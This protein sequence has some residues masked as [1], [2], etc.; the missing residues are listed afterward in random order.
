MNATRLKRVS[1]ITARGRAAAPF[2]LGMTK[3]FA[4]NDNGLYPVVRGRSE[5]LFGGY[6]L[7]P[8]APSLGGRPPSSL[9]PARNPPCHWQRR[10]TRAAAHCT[11]YAAG[12]A[13][14]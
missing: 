11:A 7:F 12:H 4:L 14:A 1:R 5:A 3:Q 13:V 8:T 9:G 6:P 10:T 2:H